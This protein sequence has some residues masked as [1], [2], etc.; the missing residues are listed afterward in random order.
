M[1][2]K[3]KSK[4]ALIPARMGSTRVPHK[5]IKKLHGKHLMGYSIEAALNS[6][7]FDKVVCVTDSPKYAQIALSYGAEVPFLRNESNAQ[8]GSPDVMWVKEVL[9]KFEKNNTYFDIF[10]I[11][12]PTSPFRTSKTIKRAMTEFLSANGIDSLRAVEKCTQ[13]P[14]KMWMSMGSVMYPLLPFSN[15]GV[16]W[17][18][19]QT[20]ELPEIL[21]QN[22]SLEICWTNSFR[23]TGQISGHKVIP[24]ITQGIE[25]FDIN[26]PDDWRMA[27]QIYQNT[28]L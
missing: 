16:P 27:E 25:G 11:L 21:V 6:N 18:S 28:K 26:T 7:E 12:R 10:A 9:G 17:H 1:A 14:G 19:N 24:F 22:A 20:N 2:D 5:N 15:C 8:T 4:V 23:Q 3:K 13:H